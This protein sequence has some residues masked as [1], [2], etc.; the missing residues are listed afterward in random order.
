MPTDEELKLATEQVA[1]VEA[2]EEESAAFDVQK[3]GEEAEK[4]AAEIMKMGET[5]VEKVEREAAA[6]PALGKYAEEMRG[7]VEEAQEVRK[8]FF[9]RL[10]ERVGITSEGRLRKK[11]KRLAEVDG[12][13]AIK[14]LLGRSKNIYKRL[15]KLSQYS[16]ETKKKK[17]GEIQ[18][19]L[20]ILLLDYK[21]AEKQDATRW[22]EVRNRLNRYVTENVID[23]VAKKDFEE[24]IEWWKLAPEASAD[25]ASR[26]IRLAVDQVYDKFIES[27]QKEGRY[28]FDAQQ[29]WYKDPERRGQLIKEKLGQNVDLWAQFIFVEHNDG[30]PAYSA[31][32]QPEEQLA[33]LQGI[34]DSKDTKDIT[35]RFPLRN[36]DRLP[37]ESVS[38]DVLEKLFDAYLEE[39][40]RFK[41]IFDHVDVFQNI[42]DNL[43]PE[44]RKKVIDKLL[45][46]VK[47]EPNYHAGDNR[48]ARLGEFLDRIKVTVEEYGK[49]VECFEKNT[50]RGRRGEKFADY[51]KGSVLANELNAEN[52]GRSRAEREQIAQKWFDLKNIPNCYDHP[53]THSVLATQVAAHPEK[54]PSFDADRARE[55]LIHLFLD[56]VRSIQAKQ[57]DRDGYAGYTSLPYS[58]FSTAQ[59]LRARGVLPEEVIQKI[60]L[61]GIETCNQEAHNRLRSESQNLLTTEELRLAA[62]R[63]VVDFVYGLEGTF[64]KV[65]NGEIKYSPEQKKALLERIAG[66]SIGQ[67]EDF[68]KYHF[69]KRKDLAVEESESFVKRLVEYRRDFLQVLAAGEYGG[70]V[71]LTDLAVYEKFALKHFPIEALYE[72]MVGRSREG[73][74]NQRVFAAS[75]ELWRETMRRL[76]AESQDIPQLLWLAVGSYTANDDERPTQFLPDDFVVM[77]EHAIQMNESARAVLAFFEHGLTEH[78]A[79]IIEGLLKQKRGKDV[80]TIWK[81]FRN[82]LPEG[83]VKEIENYILR[84][85]DTELCKALYDNFA[86]ESDRNAFGFDEHAQAFFTPERNTLIQERIIEKADPETLVS[87]LRADTV[88]DAALGVMNS[89]GVIPQVPKRKLEVASGYLVIEDKEAPNNFHM[90]PENRDKIVRALAKQAPDQLL[91]QL[92]SEAERGE[93]AIPDEGRQRFA[94]AV[95]ARK[96]HESLRVLIKNVRLLPDQVERIADMYAAKATAG[97]LNECRQ[98][99]A[100]NLATGEDPEQRMFTAVHLTPLYDAVIDS[101]KGE[102]YKNIFD[103]DSELFQKRFRVFL[104]AADV[105]TEQKMFDAV[106]SWGVPLDEN[107]TRT[108]K[109]FCDRCLRDNDEE[110][111]VKLS[112]VPFFEERL[113]LFIQN[114]M[115]RR[116]HVALVLKRLSDRG[117]LGD[118]YIEKAHALVEQGE[119]KLEEVEI[120][121]A[122]SEVIVSLLL[123]DGAKL[124][125]LAKDNKISLGNDSK[126]VKDMASYVADLLAQYATLEE[127]KKAVAERADQIAAYFDATTVYDAA[128]L[129][130]YIALYRWGG[131]QEAKKYIEGLAEKAKGLVGTSIPEE[132]RK[133]PEYMYLV[134][135]V[136]PAG[137]YSDHERNVACG[138]KLEHLAGYHFKR[139]GY[140]AQLTG[141]LGYELKVVQDEE[142]GERTDLD[143]RELL[144]DYQKRIKRI[145]EFVASRGP[146]NA[147]LQEAF[148]EKI[149][150]YFGEYAPEQYKTLEGLNMK[151]KMLTLFIGEVVKRANDKKYVPNTNIL[152]VVIE[153][154]YAF[155]EDLEGY[156]Q[157][158]ASDVQRYKDPASQR[159][160]LWQ[161]LSTIYGEN[162][163]HVLRHNIFEDLAE[164]G[165]CY[166][167]IIEI[168]GDLIG[169][170]REEWQ[171]KDKQIERIK[172]T[173]DNDKIALDDQTVTDK[174]G[175]EKVKPGKF[176]VLLK[177]VK[178]IFGSNIKFQN[179]EDK[180]NFEAEISE[181]MGSIRSD[182]NFD[183]FER[184]VGKLFKIR[185]RYRFGVGAKLEELFTLDLNAIN[186]EVAKFDEKVE[187]EAK[188]ERMNGP[189]DKM[190]KKSAKK[191][192]IRSFITKTQET[193]NARMGAFIC[194]AGDTKMWENPNYFESVDIDEETGEC[195]GLTMLLNIDANDGKKYLWFGP[196]PFESALT[197]ISAEQYLN[198]D[199]AVAVA[200]AEVNGYDG[201][202]VP[203]E[204][205]QILGSCTNRGGNFPD[206]I[207]AKRLRSKNGD[208]KIVDFGKKHTLGGS[209]GYEKGALIW[210]K[211]GV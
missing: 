5:F 86:T 60:V 20:R 35:A 22:E 201:V 194:I 46:S 26:I 178:D 78:Y 90:S 14:D 1:Q 122:A 124:Q 87:Y 23:A 165:E 38:N 150:R 107:N 62:E 203:P 170:E 189:R 30:H 92:I 171:L 117:V 71:S 161:E 13:D 85:G 183:N 94:D 89:G 157:R 142:G 67:V 140:E 126:M 63:R 123:K 200:F 132:L 199:Y 138:D 53:D 191:R 209:Y 57:K 51:I 176:N 8:S 197:K 134:K 2:A 21:K 106:L 121:R 145:K 28:E 93:I 52:T 149:D 154:K 69:I 32:A 109:R 11:E 141:L 143:D 172:N 210:A 77:R 65:Q 72:E 186:R 195:Q 163:K 202:V 120:A 185:D 112:K 102:F 4:A 45:E 105:K 192:C 70:R 25:L 97:G 96:E 162:V 103:A 24:A 188:Q 181:I 108:F 44:K 130:A 173:F 34:V 104:D 36:L 29:L 101:F 56:Q 110:R 40:A 100:A 205:S 111:L 206:L 16:P 151:E 182:F 167:D 131:E 187:V 27:H 37:K 58:Y 18:A 19:D 43:D 15:E 190:V 207:K 33:A 135:L 128:A 12:F 127:I 144:A 158:S 66:Q 76:A 50:S 169:G 98:L 175:V 84:E 42:I 7:V 168:F 146:D 147:L 180:E 153:Y 59:Y 17:K 148:T 193:T 41:Y 49:I 99:I 48:V 164:N 196:N 54:Y 114:E 118:T 125:A 133:L 177:Q 137:N 156:I 73:S 115:N 68:F 139:E 198:H 116:S 10:D 166:E 160:L 31:L 75:P 61:G 129:D 79:P 81:K 64:N 88:G 91:I 174:N 83:A 119:G 184:N 136:F 39:P 6:D 152:D 55:W 80:F 74:Y 47:E 155:H 204:D 82:D 179:N 208:L 113:D 211:K 95:I 159:A 9:E 3:A